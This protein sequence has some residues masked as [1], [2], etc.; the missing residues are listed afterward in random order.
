M[1]KTN[2]NAKNA[3]VQRTSEVRCTWNSK[4]IM[5]EKYE[6]H[7]KG[8]LDADWHEW[9]PGFTLSHLPNGTTLLRGQ[10]NDQPA[11]HGVLTRI[12][13]LGLPLLRVEHISSIDDDQ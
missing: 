6:I 4:T 12:N 13:Q 7:L 1:R 8:I 3:E 11:L 9:F 2:P 5:S 10:V